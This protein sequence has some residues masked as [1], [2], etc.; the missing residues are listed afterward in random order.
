MPQALVPSPRC[1]Q[2]IPHTSPT[3]IDLL[4]PSS[5]GSSGTLRTH[6]G[7]TKMEF[8]HGLRCF[9]EHTPTR[10]IQGCQCQTSIPSWCA[11]FVANF[12]VVHPFT[13]PS[14]TELTLLHSPLEYSDIHSIPLL[15]DLHPQNYNPPFKAYCP[16]SNICPSTRLDRLSPLP[17]PFSGIWL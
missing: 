13:P 2:L 16:K 14:A 5:V 9:Q 12:T 15:H 4:I 10:L 6:L 11:L 8:V 7:D 3:P 17:R 1:R